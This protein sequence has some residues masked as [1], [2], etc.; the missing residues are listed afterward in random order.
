MGVHVHKIL[1]H[2]NINIFKKIIHNQLPSYV[3][4]FNRRKPT[5]HA[6]KTCVPVSATDKTQ[7]KYNQENQRICL[8]QDETGSGN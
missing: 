2:I 6:Y 7:M 1:I 3:S 8:L 4:V 5:N